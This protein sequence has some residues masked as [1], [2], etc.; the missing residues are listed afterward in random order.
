MNSNLINLFSEFWELI[1]LVVGSLGGL[2][3]YIRNRNKS[4]TQL[5]QTIE[6]LKIQILD[7]IEKEIDVANDLAEKEKLLNEMRINC[8]ECY[9]K[10]VNKNKSK[11]NE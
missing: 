9:E 8:P 11:K 4:N 7:N 10:Y 1:I 2:F 3:N 6:D 5:Y